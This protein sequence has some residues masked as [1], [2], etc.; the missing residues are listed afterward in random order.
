M[1]SWSVL[2]M[3]RHTW[4]WS[5]FFFCS[6][7][8]SFALSDVSVRVSSRLEKNRKSW[9]IS[10]F[11]QMVNENHWTRRWSSNCRWNFRF[12]AMSARSQSSSVSKTISVSHSTMHDC[13]HSNSYLVVHAQT[14]LNAIGLSLGESAHSSC[15]MRVQCESFDITER[16][17]DSYV[18]VSRC[19][20]SEHSSDGSFWFS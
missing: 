5:F 12:L 20:R 15:S 1:S 6:P 8:H 13:R 17:I 2:N 14:K 9:R 10:I 18:D 3:N 4:K 19:H 11:V 7:I 16:S